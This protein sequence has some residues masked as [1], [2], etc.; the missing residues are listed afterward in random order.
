MREQISLRSEV[1]SE[2]CE[3]GRHIQIG[4]SGDAEKMPD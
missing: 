1:A 3:R 4:V 2:A